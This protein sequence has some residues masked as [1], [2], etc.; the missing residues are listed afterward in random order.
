MDL[1]TPK[2]QSTGSL[3]SQVRVMREKNWRM[4]TRRN[5][6]GDETC[7]GVMYS[8]LT[9]F[10]L[11][12]TR[13]ID[14]PLVLDFPLLPTP[15]WPYNCT[16]PGKP[17]AALLLYTPNSSTTVRHVLDAA[18]PAL[19]EPVPACPVGY[20]S[21]DAL[22]RALRADREL[23]E[24]TAAVIEFGTLGR[25]ESAGGASWSYTIAVPSNVT[26]TLGLQEGRIQPKCVSWN[27]AGG[28]WVKYC[29][30]ATPR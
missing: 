14:S 8:V 11:M 5:E 9:L 6:M 10:G 21:A 23:R 28:L 22:H 29:R 4:K 27:R 3:W 24:A 17:G 15:A 25:G 7:R 2:P 20:S 18:L 26:R 30:T 19:G 16:T 13:W 12:S 1:L